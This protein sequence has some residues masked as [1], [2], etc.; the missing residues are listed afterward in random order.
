[1]NAKGGGGK[2]VPGFIDVYEVDAGANVVLITW[3]AQKPQ[4]QKHNLERAIEASMGTIEVS[5]GP[6]AAAGGAGGKANT[7]CF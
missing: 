3:L 4:A 2:M 7:G 1:M 6:D 5:A